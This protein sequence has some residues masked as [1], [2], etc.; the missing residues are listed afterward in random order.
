MAARISVVQDG[1]LKVVVFLF[2][3]QYQSPVR[4]ERIP[5]RPPIGQRNPERL[6]DGVDDLL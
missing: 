6:A 1:V 2:G 3:V 4:R 5:L